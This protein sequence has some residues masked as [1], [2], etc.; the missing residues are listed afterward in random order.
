MRC[1]ERE[2]YNQ[3]LDLF[4]A[5]ADELGLNFSAATF[6]PRVIAVQAA[7]EKCKHAREA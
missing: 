2:R 4:T 5:C 3:A 6:G 7:K 1:I